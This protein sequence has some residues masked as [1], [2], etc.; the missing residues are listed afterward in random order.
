[1]KRLSLL[2]IVAAVLWSCDKKAQSTETQNTEETTAVTPAATDSATVATAAENTPTT[3]TPI[4]QEFKVGKV[5]PASE[6]PQLTQTATEPGKK[7]KFNPPH[8][9]PFHRCD[10]EVGAPIDSAPKAAAPAPQV[11]NQPAVNQ[12]FNTNPIPAAPQ[13]AATVPAQNIGPKP[14]FNP[15]HG[16]P[17]HRCDIQ[18]GAP[19]T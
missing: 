9:E 2:M 6:N 14:A 8:G 16:E 17:H 18:V 4:P 3:A 11:M 1:M 5:V 7:P 19:L 10:I 15:P 13:P 12:N